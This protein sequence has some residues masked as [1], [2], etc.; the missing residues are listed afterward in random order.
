MKK[1]LFI[2][3]LLTLA[4]TQEIILVP[5]DYPTIQSAINS[6]ND[7]D[8]ILV[9]SGT[10]Y[11][12]INYNGKNISIIG[13]SRETTFIDGSLPNPDDNSSVVTF[14]NGE[15]NLAIIE[16][17]T[18]MNGNNTYGGGLYI[19]NA[20][21]NIRNLYIT[22]NTSIGGGGAG[23]FCLDANPILVNVDIFNNNS[24]DV[25]GGIY[26]KGNSDAEFYNIAIYNNYGEGAGG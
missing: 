17:F 2:L 25:G 18:I 3:S 23:I 1:Y 19:D 14:N 9:S 12:N 10:Y 7:N 20:N 8:T 21:P 4:S 24:D 22:N 6:S 15:N 5:Q 11:E 16:G 13:E 26:L